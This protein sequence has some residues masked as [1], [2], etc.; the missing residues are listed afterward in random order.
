VKVQDVGQAGLHGWK[1]K[2][3]DKVARRVPVRD[4]YVR[5]AF[6]LLFLGLSLRY[7]AQT[8]RELAARR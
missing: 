1:E 7:L 5:A 3:A 8:A 2:L 4:D 6:G